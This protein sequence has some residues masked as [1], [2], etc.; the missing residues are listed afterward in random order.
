MLS[1]ILRQM[2]RATRYNPQERKRALQGCFANVLPRIERWGVSKVVS[3]PNAMTAEGRTGR[4][5]RTVLVA[6][7]L[8]KCLGRVFEPCLKFC[9]GGDGL[10]SDGLR[11]EFGPTQRWW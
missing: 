4:T 3:V 8:G 7:V 10:V 2:D 11:G 5:G 9:V 6:V 1:V